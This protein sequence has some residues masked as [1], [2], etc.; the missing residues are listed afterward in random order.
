MVIFASAVLAVLG[1]FNY[2]SRENLGT[3]R[4]A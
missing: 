2:D 1:F 4:A 3:R